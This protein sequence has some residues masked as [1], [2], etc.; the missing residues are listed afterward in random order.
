M[1]D[2]HFGRALTDHQ[3]GRDLTIA[4]QRQSADNQGLT[5]SLLTLAEVARSQHDIGLA[6]QVLADQ[7]TPAATVR[8]RR[9]VISPLQA[10]IWLVAKDQPGS[11]VLL[12]AAADALVHDVGAPRAA[13]VQQMLDE[14]LA[15][16]RV[17]LDARRYAA[18]WADGAHSWAGWQPTTRR[19][20]GGEPHRL[21][22]WRREPK[23]SINRLAKHAQGQTQR[24]RR[25][26]G[27][28]FDA[29]AGRR[30]ALDL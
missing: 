11:A 6:R 4:I 16:A 3:R 2:V 10:I 14:S 23:N 17:A 1:L 29:D 19:L 22:T 28:P 9:A 7:L 25:R 20:G 13:H 24:G 5:L 27:Q 12:A 8:D 18:Q 26:V 15:T 21:A 30:A